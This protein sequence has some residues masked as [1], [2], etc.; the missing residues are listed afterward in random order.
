MRLSGLR[1][2]ADSD[3]ELVVRRLPARTWA[4]SATLACGGLAAAIALVRAPS[5]AGATTAWLVLGGALLSALALSA[6]VRIEQARLDV[7]SQRLRVTSVATWRAALFGCAAAHDLDAQARTV[8]LSEITAVAIETEHARFGRST[9]SERAWVVRHAFR[10][11][12]RTRARRRVAL[13]RQFWP[14]LA[15]AKRIVKRIKEH[16]PAGAQLEAAPIQLDAVSMLM[17]ESEL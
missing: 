10:V 7:A 12:V 8:G 4:C 13:T 17:D 3:A 14:G 1:V 5:A 16:L 2:V 15:S 11:V 6:L 9:P